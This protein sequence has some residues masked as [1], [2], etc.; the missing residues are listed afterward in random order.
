MAIYNIKLSNILYDWQLSMASFRFG[1]T[2]LLHI[3]P[4]VVNKKKESTR[5]RI[6]RAVLLSTKFW[7]QSWIEVF[8]LWV[9]TKIRICADQKTADLS[10]SKS[11]INYI[12]SSN[13]K[14][15]RDVWVWEKRQEQRRTRDWASSIQSI[16]VLCVRQKRSHRGFFVMLKSFCEID[17]TSRLAVCDFLAWF[18]WLG[19]S[20]CVC[21]L[22]L[23]LTAA[24]SVSL[25]LIVSCSSCWGLSLIN[26]LKTTKSLIRHD[27]VLVFA[28]RLL[29]DRRLLVV[30]L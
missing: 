13:L 19:P 22:F 26:T 10:F 9:G 5:V 15:A 4:F 18:P 29:N 11:E 12:T 24:N 14:N 2:Y 20:V 8:P 23:C 16:R 28:Y 3:R 27:F 25:H 7:E 21:M 17:L 6:V 1:E 30:E